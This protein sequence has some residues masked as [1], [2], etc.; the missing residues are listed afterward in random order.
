MH[1]FST[2]EQGGGNM[3]LFNSGT[4]CGEFMDSN[5]CIQFEYI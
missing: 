5:N 4:Y 3:L 2:T 1:L